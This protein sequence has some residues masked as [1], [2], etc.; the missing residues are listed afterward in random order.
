MCFSMIGLDMKYFKFYH[1]SSYKMVWA[2]MVF[3]IFTIPLKITLAI[4]WNM[5]FTQ[6]FWLL[7]AICNGDLWI[8]WTCWIFTQL[9]QFI[10]HWVRFMCFNML[11]TSSKVTTAWKS[12]LSVCFESYCNSF[13]G[14]CFNFVF[15]LFFF[16]Q[17]KAC[18]EHAITFVPKKIIW[19]VTN[20]EPCIRTSSCTLYWSLHL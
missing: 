19:R 7:M 2:S 6:S 3:V 12:N 18:C 17:V 4:R 13:A 15:Y 10:H 20:T 8:S 11:Q 14:K 1:W 16:F 9:L 5:T